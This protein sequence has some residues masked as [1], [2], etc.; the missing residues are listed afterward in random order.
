MLKDQIDVHGAKKLQVISLKYKESSSLSA[1]R[2]G[3]SQC[4]RWPFGF[5]TV[6]RK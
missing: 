3:V 6:A 2:G 4:D 5:E 1:V